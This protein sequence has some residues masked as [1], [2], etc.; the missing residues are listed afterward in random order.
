MN[1]NGKRVKKTSSLNK[2]PIIF[3]IFWT[4]SWRCGIEVCQK[5]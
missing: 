2:I 1:L 4:L 3:S 5:L